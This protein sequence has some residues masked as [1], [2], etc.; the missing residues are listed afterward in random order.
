MRGNKGAAP[1]DLLH[2]VASTGDADDLNLLLGF[3]DAAVGKRKISTSR[4]F[5]DI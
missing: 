2:N 1:G 5:W 3:H 4:G